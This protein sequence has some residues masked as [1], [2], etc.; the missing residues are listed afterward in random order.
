MLETSLPFCSCPTFLPLQEIL[1]LL[2]TGLDF[3]YYTNTTTR[4]R[5]SHLFQVSPY[6]QTLDITQQPAD[7]APTKMK[8]MKVVEKGKAEIQEV[9]MPKLRPSYVLVKVKAVA[10]NPTDW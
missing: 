8:A 4:E 2:T 1:P 5:L 6:Y 10:L 7:M 3:L 9:P